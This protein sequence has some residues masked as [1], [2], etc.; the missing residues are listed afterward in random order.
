MLIYRRSSEDNFEVIEALLQIIKDQYKAQ[1]LGEMGIIVTPDL[2]GF[3][4][5]VIDQLTSSAVPTEIK[6]QIGGARKEAL[7]ELRGYLR[8]G[9]DRL[10]KINV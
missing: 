3:P 1:L 8:I 6:K 2:G 9:L 7:N 4:R 10:D 5:E